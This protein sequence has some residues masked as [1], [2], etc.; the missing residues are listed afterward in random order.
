MAKRQIASFS[1]IQM[2]FPESRCLLYKCL[3]IE[4][5][6]I[7][8]LL[9]H[10]RYFMM[11]SKYEV[12]WDSNPGLPKGVRCQKNFQMPREQCSFDLLLI[13]CS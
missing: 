9:I 1:V 4:L 2:H 6:H 13:C 10:E 12:L 3:H 11:G 5:E 8:S 7:P